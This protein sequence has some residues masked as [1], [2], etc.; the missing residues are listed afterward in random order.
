MFHAIMWLKSI[1]IKNAKGFV[2]SGVLE[3]SEGVN[4]LVGANNAGKS[5]ILRSIQILQPTNASGTFFNNS[6]RVGTQS[7][8]IILELSEPNRN[9]LNVPADW[10]LTNWKPKIRS[11]VG[12]Q[13]Q[14]TIL[15]PNGNWQGAPQPMC[16]PHEPRNFIYPYF[17]GRKTTDFNLQVNENNTRLVEENFQHLP[18]KIDRLLNPDFPAFDSFRN[19]C[20]T[21]LGLKISSTLWGA[22]KHAGLLLQDQTLLPISNMG[23]GTLHILAF[24]THLC[25]ATGKLFLI[26]EIENDL[27][28]KALKRL[29]EFIIEKS[30]SN[31]FIVTTHNNIVVRYLGGAPKS[32]VFSLEMKLEESSKIPICSCQPVPD[33]PDKRISLL[34]NL[35]YDV[36]DSFLWKGYLILEESTAERIIREVLIPNFYPSL[37]LKLR[38]IAARG[39]QNVEPCFNDFHRLFVFV[40]TSPA[41][42]ER[43]WVAVDGSAEGKNTIEKLKAKFSK[44]WPENHFKWFFAEQFEEY[45]PK[46]FGQKVSEVIAMPHGLPKQKAKGD[47][48]NEIVNWALTN[49]EKAKVEFKE[50]AK[51]VLEFLA[52]I[53]QKLA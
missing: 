31:Q 50:S 19:A 45:Y 22:G 21:I 46:E 52:E 40:H 3:F 48:A 17:S 14:F 20:N 4:V 6:L 29:L 24:L 12:Q 38:T 15:A 27:H 28:P 18:S 37:L 9:R 13:N 53:D 43:A 23:E 41:Y 5:T 1:Q 30:Q 7:R 51:E 44:D 26:E 39:V 42:K 32:K 11:V 47:L 2:D 33:E 35:G 25:S 10:N 34:E 49:P 8:E 16:D 36:F